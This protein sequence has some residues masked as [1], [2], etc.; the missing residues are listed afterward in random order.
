V[1]SQPNLFFR[2][3][4]LF[5]ACQGLADD[6]GI[7]ALWLRVPLAAS[8][9]YDPR[10]AFGIYA[11]L[12]VAVFAARKIWPAKPVAVETEQAASE[13]APV[14]VS[15]NDEQRELALAA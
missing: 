5:G 4:T 1:T 10:I 11:V 13:T 6:L 14:A 9:L 2:Q 7:N 15:E 8:I 12:C 3:D